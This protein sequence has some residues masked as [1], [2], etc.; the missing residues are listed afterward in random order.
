VY[1][2]GGVER[3]SSAKA[4]GCRLRFNVR[5]VV[6]VNYTIRRSRFPKRW[7]VVLHCH[8]GVELPPT[9]LIARAGEIQPM[10][11]GQ[12]TEV[13]RFPAATVAAGEKLALPFQ[14]QAEGGFTYRLFPAEARRDS[15]IRFVDP[16]V[17]ERQF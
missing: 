8:R 7:S 12:G 3:V 15:A 16:P 10:H 6:R 14:T 4:L 5:D 2:Q 17:R 1:Q 11:R 9:V 13:S